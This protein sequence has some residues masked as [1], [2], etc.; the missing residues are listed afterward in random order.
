MTT[1]AEQ[2][3]EKACKT[4]S[5]NEAS[6]NLAPGSDIE[7]TASNTTALL[8][9]ALR[10]VKVSSMHARDFPSTLQRDLK[11]LASLLNDSLR[12]SNSI[13]DGILEMGEY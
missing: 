5:Q 4:Q 10:Q 6:L 1:K 7:N 11:K 3:I 12:L 8:E 9:E 2:L 13:L